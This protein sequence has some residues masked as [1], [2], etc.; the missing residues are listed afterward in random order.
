[1]ALIKCHE[2]GQEVSTE[3]DKC[4]HCGAKPKKKTSIF[5]WIIAIFFGLI[6]FRA[7]LAPSSSSNSIPPSSPIAIQPQAPQ[8]KTWDYSTET[9][10][11]S[12]KP[13]K[14]ASIASNNTFQ[15]DF[16]YQGGSIGVLVVRKH[17]R[18]GKDVIFSV[19]KGQL[20]CTSYNGCQVSVKFDDKPAYKV[21]AEEPAD[22]SSDTLFLQGYEKLVKDMKASKKAL[23]EVTFY[24]Q[25]NKSF[26][27]NVEG[28]KWE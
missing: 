25:G 17:P 26:E 14:R 23:V 7:V 13:S 11:V 1:M 21:S 10:K 9:D 12:D 20:L 6:L 24:Q 15:L 28:L 8:P 18:F 22:H 4:P 2:C 5:T 16:P 19:S 27:F 3:A